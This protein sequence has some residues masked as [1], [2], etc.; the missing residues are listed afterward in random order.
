MPKASEELVLDFSF[1]PRRWYHVVIAHSAGS[2]LV[3]PLVRLF[4]DSV[5]EASGRLR[6]PKVR[7][8]MLQRRIK[9]IQRPPSLYDAPSVHG[10][11]VFTPGCGNTR[12]MSWGWYH[13]CKDKK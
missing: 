8:A 9:V 1:R 7:R 13:G 6:Y 4:V 10:W 12:C 11:S 3:H 5:P 2:A